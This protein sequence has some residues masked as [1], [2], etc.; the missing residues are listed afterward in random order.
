MTIAAERVTIWPNPDWTDNPLRHYLIVLSLYLCAAC[1]S[2]D[3]QVELNGERFTVELSTTP[4]QQALGL[5]FRDSMPEDHGMLF[6]FPSEA[7]RSFWMKNT[8][9]PLDIFYFDADL[10][11]VSVSENARPCR[12]AQCPSFLS[13]GP[14]R[15]VLELNAG[16]A[17][18]LGTKPGDELLLDLE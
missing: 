1:V 2:A 4:K 10:K 13:A 11:L 5:M 6:I 7:T 12:V 9:I 18:E 3:P 16:K 14:A 17:A 8:R 15:Y